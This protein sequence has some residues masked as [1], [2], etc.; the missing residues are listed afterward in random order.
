MLCALHRSLW[1]CAVLNDNLLM[2]MGI[3]QGEGKSGTK[4]WDICPSVAPGK[5]SPSGE[6]RKAQGVQHLQSAL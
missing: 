4:S 2:F 1:G 5:Y 3:S 6:D